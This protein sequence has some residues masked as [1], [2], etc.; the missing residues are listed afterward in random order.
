MQTGGLHLLFDVT[1]DFRT[2]A[3]TF[4]VSR[5]DAVI[6]THAHA[7]HVMGFDDIRRF[8][9]LQNCAIPAYGS[10]D[11]IEDLNRIFDYFHHDHPPGVYRP[12]IN[13]NPVTG[14]FNIG[15][16]LLTP[17]PV[18]HGQKA[19]LG[20]RVESKGKSFGYV[21][22]CHNMTD[23]VIE[24]FRNLD[25][26]ILDALRFKPHSTHLSLSESVETLKRINARKSFIIHMGHDLDH[27]TTRESLPESMDVSH[28]GLCVEW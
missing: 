20:Y 3:L 16:A 28:D 25:V 27:E 10:P 7:D 12:E 19:T 2:Q 23:D 21:P 9:T 5:V 18:S 22:D 11:T 6:F 14:P 24:S 4:K 15:S 1:P 8:N 17:I 26:M 13:Y